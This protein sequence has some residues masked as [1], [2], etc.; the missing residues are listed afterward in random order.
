VLVRPGSRHRFAALRD[1]LGA[2]DAQ[3]RSVIGDVGEPGLAMGEGWSR[4]CPS[5]NISS[6][7]LPLNRPATAME[8]TW[9]SRAAPIAVVSATVLRVPKYRTS[10]LLA[11]NPHPRARPR[12]DRGN[13][14]RTRCATIDISVNICPEA[15]DPCLKPSSSPPVARPSAAP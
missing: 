11:V 15:F 3:L 7:N 12:I 13:R 1:R 4:S 2:S 6:L 10:T 5:A 8:L 14:R 9:C